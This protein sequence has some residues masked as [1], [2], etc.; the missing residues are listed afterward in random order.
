MLLKIIFYGYMNQTFSSRL[1]AKKLCS[2][3]GFMYL[4]ANNK[5]D[6]RTIN[7]FRG[8]RLIVVKDIFK[9]IVIMLKRL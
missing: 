6:F 7:R 2:D 5:P 1:I 4:A 8:E 3:L 9:Q